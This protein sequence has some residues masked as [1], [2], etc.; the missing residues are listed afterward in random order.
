MFCEARRTFAAG[1]HHK[2]ERLWLRRSLIRN[3]EIELLGDRL[4]Q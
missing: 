1:G 4:K 3:Y 2:I